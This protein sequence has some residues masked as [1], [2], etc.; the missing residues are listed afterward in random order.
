QAAE[1]ALGDTAQTARHRLAPQRRRIVRILGIEKF[2]ST[3]EA[4]VEAGIKLLDAQGQG[5]IVVLLLEWKEQPAIEHITG[6]GQGGHQKQG[7]Q[8]GR[9]YVT[10]VHEASEEWRTQDQRHQPA[11]TAEESHEPQPSAHGRETMAQ[12]SLL[13]TGVDGAGDSWR[14]P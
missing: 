1:I 12:L 10:P 13:N 5:E 2:D 11:A 14:H 9:Q 6:P 4:V 3:G 7:P 8:Q